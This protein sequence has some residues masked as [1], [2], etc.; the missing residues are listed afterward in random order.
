[1]NTTTATPE[2]RTEL[3]DQIGQAIKDAIAS[4]APQADYCDSREVD[5]LADAVLAVV[6][7]LL[8]D[9]DQRLL[10]MTSAWTVGRKLLAAWQRGEVPPVDPAMPYYVD[11]AWLD[12]APVENG[13][14]AQIATSAALERKPFAHFVQPSSFGPFL[15]CESSQVGAFPAFRQSTSAADSEDAALVEVLAHA[16]FH[17][18]GY[19]QSEVDLLLL[20][21]EVAA[22]AKKV[23]S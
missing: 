16:A 18:F 14:G 1:M 7:P 11:Q 6:L 13:P 12:A 21:K 8:A 9:R 4:G 23:T 5:R 2:A 22:R 3:R 17:A 20:F 10:T 15:E 19:E